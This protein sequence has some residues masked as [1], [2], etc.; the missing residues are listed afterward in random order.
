[1]KQNMR[2]SHIFVNN[3]VKTYINH[4]ILGSMRVGTTHVETIAITHGLY[5]SYVI[6]AVEMLEKAYKRVN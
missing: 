3:N 2:V 1:M 5:H 6:S 4:P